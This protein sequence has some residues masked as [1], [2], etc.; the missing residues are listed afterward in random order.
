MS[1]A[2]PILKEFALQA[3]ASLDLVEF[4]ASSGW[5]TSFT[6]RNNIRFGGLHGDAADIDDSIADAFLLK[7]PELLANYS[8]RDIFNAD[9]S[10]FYYRQLLKKSFIGQNETGRGS[11][12]L[13]ERVS[14]LF[15]CSQLGEKLKPVV[16][17]NAQ[18]PRCFKQNAINSTACLPVHYY[19]NSKAWMTGEIFKDWLKT[20]NREMKRQ[21]RKVLI[22]VDNASCHP[23]IELSN[24]KLLFF[25]PNMTSKL[26]PLDQG[27]IKQTKSI[28]RKCLL[29]R[30]IQDFEDVE[31]CLALLKS[32]N[33]L[34]AIRYICYAW[35]EVKE[36]TIQKCFKNAG[37]PSE[38][39][40]E[41]GDD[42]E[43]N[44]LRS[45]EDLINVATE[46]LNIEIE[47]SEILDKEEDQ[48]L[49]RENLGETAQEIATGILSA[50]EIVESD[51]SDREQEPEEE[52]ITIDDALKCCEKLIKFSANNMPLYTEKLFKLKTDIE[53]HQHVTKMNSLQQKS[54]LDYIIKE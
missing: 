29:E 45:Y 48:A 25:P 42:D 28:Y 46:N 22:T 10:G 8:S 5:L 26:Q 6:H 1:L 53:K 54:M 43:E 34:D 52:E 30:I 13:K 2:G 18:K 41:I 14:V 21:G 15:C 39:A 20:I 40:V 12:E 38:L 49:I 51:E 19:A 47:S 7:L 4:K 37:F 17:G 33:V 9:E 3:A 16:I 44:L 23:N 31:S 35:N 24:V 27:I 32:I 11:K 50:N 36:S